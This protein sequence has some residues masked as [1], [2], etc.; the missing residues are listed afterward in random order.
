[1]KTAR[2]L[3]FAAAML[4]VVPSHAGQDPPGSGPVA[5]GPDGFLIQSESGDFKLQVRGHV[6]FDGRFYLGDRARAASDAFTLRRVRPIVSGS[7]GKHFEFN[8]TPD[9]G[10]GVTVLQDAY[11]DVK[12]AA[13]AARLRIGK[14]KAP[15]G[16]ERLQQANAIRFV[17][18]ALPTGLVP[19]RDLGVQLQ[20]E[21]WG[22]VLAYAAGVFNGAPDGGSVGGDLGDGKDV[23]ARI[24]VFPFRRGKSALQNLGLGVAATTG[25]QAGALPTYRTSGQLALFTYSSGAVADGERTRFAP[26]LLLDSGRFGLLAEFVQSSAVVARPPGAADRLRHRAWQVASSVLLTRH[27]AAYAGVKPR[28]AFDP[29]QG[30]WGAVELAARVNGI[31]LDADAFTRGYAEPARSARKAFAWGV[32]LNWYLSRNVKHM[33]SFERT[34]FTGGAATGDRPAENALFV[35]SQVSF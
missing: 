20:G 21:L 1:M 6:H 33:V 8:I 15:V 13:K 31:E 4:A 9:F 18:R 28:E 27:A 34:R 19:N 14:T 30:H 25:R 23:A 3:A 29:A 35:R 12:L 2:P 7:L 17:E 11:L 32:G 26:Q 22:A 5:A 10:G 16:L 24:L